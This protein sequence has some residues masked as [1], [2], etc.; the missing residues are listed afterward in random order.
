M[1]KETR[2]KHSKSVKN[3]WT[4]D[5]QRKI[6]AADIRIRNEYETTH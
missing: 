2:E 3:A 1:S 6:Q 4:T 5:T